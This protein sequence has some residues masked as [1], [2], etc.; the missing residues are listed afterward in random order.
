M[1]AAH[2]R[3]VR[4]EGRIA[5]LVIGLALALLTMIGL[6][7]DGGGKIR[8]LQRA[9]HLAA[10]A[11]R[12]AGQAIDAPQAIIGGDKVVDPAAAAAAAR[13][14]LAAAG[15]TGT[16]SVAD[17]RQHITVTVTI[18]NRTVFLGLIGV[19]TL[20]STRQASAVLVVT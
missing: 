9:D 8:A 13:S 15:A 12:A 5:L 10:E 11:A 2:R 6:S 14:Y 20:S 1:T 3:P 4:D 17:D 18:V 19:D 7:V 16:V